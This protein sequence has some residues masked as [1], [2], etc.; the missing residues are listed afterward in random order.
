M[1]STVPHA[2]VRAPSE[3]VPDQPRPNGGLV[4]PVPAYAAGA[5]DHDALLDAHGDRGKWR[6][7]SDET[8]HAIHES[9]SL[10]IERVHEA[11]DHETAWTVAAYEN[12]VSDRMWILTATGGTPAPCCRSCWITS[13]A[14]T[15]GTGGH[16]RHAWLR[17]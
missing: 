8:T 17:Q 4:E 11:P 10:R 15:A 7:W 5:G 2:T 3:S 9:Q 6:A 13:P 14:S 1:I 12:P 16:R